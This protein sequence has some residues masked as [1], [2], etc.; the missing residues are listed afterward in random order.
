VL[1][2]GPI[3]L[4]FEL[5]Y[6]A[7]DASGAK[8]SEVKRV[9]LDAGSQWNRVESAFTAKKGPLSIGIGIAKHADSAVAVDAAAGTMRVWEP[10]DKGKAGNLGTAIV[11]S[12]GAKLEEHHGDLDYMIVTPAATNGQLVFY[13]G[14]AWDR[15]GRIRD[16]ATWATEVQGL[17]AKLA[18][19]VKV[20]LDVS[21]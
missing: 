10:L 9:L 16:A 17:A 19:P 7:W 2:N 15:A 8:V 20:S 3:R 14:S 21:K 11:V 1:A 12:A 5:T 18:A 13:T 6:P 4:V